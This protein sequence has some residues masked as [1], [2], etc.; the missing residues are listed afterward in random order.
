LDQI[1]IG[2]VLSYYESE[3]GKLLKIEISKNVRETSAKYINSDEEKILFSEDGEFIFYDS[4]AKF[5][6]VNGEI[7]NLYLDKKG[8]IVY[9]EKV[10][11]DSFPAYLI[12]VA[13]DE[14]T[15]ELFL[16]T[17]DYDG[18]VVKRKVAEN[19]KL[20]ASKAK[21]DVIYSALTVEGKTVSQVV[22]LRTDKND[23]I[24]MID[25]VD[26][27]ENETQKST[28]KCSANNYRGQYKHHGRLVPK[29]LISPSTVVFSVPSVA[30]NDDRDYTVKSKSDFD[31][32]QWY[33]VDVYDYLENKTGYSEILVIKDK[34]WSLSGNSTYVLVDKITNELNSDDE[35]VEKLFCNKEGNMLEYTT[36]ADFSLGSIGAKSGDLVELSLNIRGEIDDAE[37]RYSYG[38]TDRPINNRY[39]AEPGLRVVYVH[40]KIG[41]VL[42]I[43][44]KSSNDFD[45]IFEMPQDRI[46]VYEDNKTERIRKGTMWDIVPGMTIAIQT[47]DETPWFV[48]VYK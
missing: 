21:F 34:T 42:K 2:D 3:D 14:S 35:A 8:Y 40:E 5:N 23:Q 31:N 36:T 13:Y 24:K 15:E 12:K 38:S 41:N 32:D 28:L 11:N 44:Y 18:K 22:V 17:L 10:K 26:K 43:G 1:E 37:I 48:V 29:V 47:I 39:N 25:T 9:L 4:N 7:V 27:G 6:V 20:D 33:T 46:V 45:E 16:K 19:A 30:T